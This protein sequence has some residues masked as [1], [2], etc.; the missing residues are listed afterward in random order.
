LAA[1]EVTARAIEV[2]GLT[3][4]DVTLRLDCSAGF[5]V[6][7]LAHDRGEGLGTGGHLSAYDARELAISTTPRP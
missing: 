2:I 4:A 6:R 5:Y 3:G 1:V 7:S